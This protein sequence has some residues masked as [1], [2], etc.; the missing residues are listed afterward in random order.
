ML[1]ALQGLVNA[2]LG[3]L[4][5]AGVLAGEGGGYG[6]GGGEGEE[7]PKPSFC[8]DRPTHQPTLE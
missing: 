1:P 6:R 5:G 7:P 4:Q 3:V 2:T 8:T